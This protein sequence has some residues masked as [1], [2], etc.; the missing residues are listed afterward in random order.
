MGPSWEMGRAQPGVTCLLL[1]RGPGPCLSLYYPPL[2]LTP[3]GASPLAS[4]FGRKTKGIFAGE[5]DG[6]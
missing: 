6:S 2:V 1:G 3:P 4:Q 5:R